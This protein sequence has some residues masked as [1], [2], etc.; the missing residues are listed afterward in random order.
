MPSAFAQRPEDTAALTP[1]RISRL[2]SACGSARNSE[3]QI[4][5]IYANEADVLNVALFGMTA[6][7]WRDANPELKGNIRDY[8]TINQLICL[9]NMESL[10]AI[11][12]NEGLPQAERLRRLNA[13]AIQQMSVLEGYETN[14]SFLK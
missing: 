3:K 10:N 8:A 5:F 11:F 9:S 7:E 6:K 1:T 2:N 14:R 4:S 12:I 13:I